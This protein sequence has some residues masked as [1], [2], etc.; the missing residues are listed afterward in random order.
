VAIEN[1]A[2]LMGLVWPRYERQS[3]RN[4]ERPQ[5]KLSTQR[6]ILQKPKI[7]QFSSAKKKNLVQKILTLSLIFSLK[8]MNYPIA[9]VVH[10]M[11]TVPMDEK[12]DIFDTE[13]VLKILGKFDLISFFRD[14]FFLFFD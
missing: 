13:N 11:L 12:I 3:A 1:Y 7:V 14:F 10:C 9:K 8:P 6:Q 5:P 4:I 2:A